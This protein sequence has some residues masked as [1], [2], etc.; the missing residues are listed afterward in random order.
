[1][2]E[3]KYEN[4]VS[5]EIN[6]NSKGYTYSVKLVRPDFNKTF[7]NKMVEILDWTENIVQNLEGLKKIK[8]ELGGD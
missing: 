8:K 2:E 5:I 4:K 1:M 3:A 7:Q 6:K